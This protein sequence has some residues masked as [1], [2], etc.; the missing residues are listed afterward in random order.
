[1]TISLIFLVMALPP[2][3]VKWIWERLWPTVNTQ[4]KVEK[5]KACIN[6]PT[7]HLSSALAV[8]SLNISWARHCIW[9]TYG[10]IPMH[11]SKPCLNSFI[12]LASTASCGN[13]LTVWLCNNMEKHFLLFILNLLPYNFIVCVCRS[14]LLYWKESYRSSQ[15]PIIFI[16]LWKSHVPLSYPF[17]TEEVH[18][19]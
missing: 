7:L 1:M 10:F 14:E 16:N 6:C 4:E 13:D 5:K 3:R 18:S 8:I 19:V 9:V 11:F 12:F 2:P 15:F 17:Q